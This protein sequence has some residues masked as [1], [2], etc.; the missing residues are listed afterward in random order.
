MEVK[1]SE[2]SPEAGKQLWEIT[3][4]KETVVGCILRGDNTIIPR[5]DT[6]IFSGDTLVVITSNGQELNTI[7]ALTGKQCL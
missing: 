6:C 7:H 4:P 5:G 2:E 3:L 1:I